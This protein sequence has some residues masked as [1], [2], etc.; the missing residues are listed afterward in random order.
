MMLD[1]TH[2]RVFAS[3]LRRTEIKFDLV[4]AV[5]ELAGQ[6]RMEFDFER[7]A[8]VMDTVAD[9]LSVSTRSS[10]PAQ[11]PWLKICMCMHWLQAALLCSLR[12]VCQ[13]HCLPTAVF[14]AALA[15]C[16]G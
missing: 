12:F 6:V 3:Y 1:L 5:D 16:Q 11:T 13:V 14:A 4:S 2:I 7:E 15:R 10:G 8:R 9:H